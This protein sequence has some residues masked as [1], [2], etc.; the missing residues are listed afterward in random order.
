MVTMNVSENAV[1]AGERGVLRSNEPVLERTRGV[2]VEPCEFERLLQRAMEILS[3][4]ARI[5][6]PGGS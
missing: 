3:V 6:T 5:A 1:Q 2:R 4:R